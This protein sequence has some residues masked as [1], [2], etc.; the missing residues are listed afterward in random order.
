MQKHFFLLIISFLLTIHA[1]QSQDVDKAKVKEDLED[2]L[3]ELESRYAYFKEKE[4]D[5]N[6][7]R[8]RYTQRIEDLKSQLDV[9]LFFEYLV[10]ELY[11][12]HVILN[13]NTYYSYRLYTPVY[14]DIKNNGFQITRVWQNEFH[15]DEDIIGADIISFND[16]KLE[17]W[18]TD[19]YT[20]C[21]DKMNPEI[22]T[23]L[24]NK[25]LSG[26][27]SEPRNL[28]IKKSNGQLTTIN[29]DSLSR[30]QHNTLLSSKVIEDNIGLITIN[31]SL[32]KAE[33]I[34]AFD[35]ALDDIMN[36]TGLII[37]LRN[38]V[39][40]GD[41][42]IARGIMRR[43]IGQTSA[44]QRHSYLEDYGN[45]EPIKRSWLEQVTPRG[46]HYAKP[47]IV[48]VGRWTGSMGEGLAIG[49]E[50]ID[51]GLVV[52]TEMQRLAGEMEGFG[53]I[54]QSFGYRLSVAKLFHVDGT[55][56]EKYVPAYPVTITSNLS[57]E[58]MDKGIQLLKKQIEN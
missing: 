47:V 34:A 4:I 50:G 2:M 26:R 55:P 57:D 5:L 30:Q 10:Y 33:T 58:I 35:K 41:S 37:D 53:F 12:S 17:S 27:Y 54:H 48:L 18:V 44:Y 43:F 21:H 52:G 40:G 45:H 42:Y 38:T 14:V 7:I 46:E 31:N 6:C 20:T 1:C 25:V 39:D 29:L 13:T 16:K 24:A 3:S 11:D 32:G 28:K 51:R 9:T 22:K 49:L 19:F 23:W 15:F 36:T 8:E 56:R